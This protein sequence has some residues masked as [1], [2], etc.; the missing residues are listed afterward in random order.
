MRPVFALA[1][2]LNPTSYPLAVFDHVVATVAKVV[3]SGSDSDDTFP[4][5]LE[6]L[7]AFSVPPNMYS[8][9]HFG[10]HAMRFL[11]Q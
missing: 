2:V 11:L 7:A 5:V 1:R 6:L 9:T 4:E 8:N 10:I 3:P